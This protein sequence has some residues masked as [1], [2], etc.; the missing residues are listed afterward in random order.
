MNKL[1]VFFLMLCVA[2]TAASCCKEVAED[3]WTNGVSFEPA[4]VTNVTSTSAEVTSRVTIRYD[5]SSLSIKK[6]ICF[7]ETN[8]MPVV[9]DL[10]SYD[11]I[12]SN[13]SIIGAN[14]QVSQTTTITVTLNDLKPDTEYFARVFAIVNDTV[15]YGEVFK[16]KT[17]P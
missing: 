8:E 3:N 10:V 16:F 4:E 6:G 14:V 17:L 15:Y 12:S 5:G 13:E 1:K 2:F 7:S 9:E 11:P